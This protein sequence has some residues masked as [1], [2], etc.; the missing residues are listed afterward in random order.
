[1]QFAESRKVVESR[2]LKLCTQPFDL[3]LLGFD[4]VGGTMTEAVMA[5]FGNVDAAEHNATAI[6]QPIDDVVSHGGPP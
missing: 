6:K 4:Q 2:L 1:L 3:G 5:R